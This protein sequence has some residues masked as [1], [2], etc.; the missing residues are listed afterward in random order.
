MKRWHYF[1]SVLSK[2]YCMPVN[3]SSPRGRKSKT[4]ERS[5]Y[6]A[7]QHISKTFQVPNAVALE[8]LT[9]VGTDPEKLAD[10]LK[11]KKK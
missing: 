5:V 8:A 6:N 7:I 2:P 4:P 10:Y 1:F 11:D 3:P 9:A